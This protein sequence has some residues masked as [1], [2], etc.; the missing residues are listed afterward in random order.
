MTCAWKERHN[1]I[2]STSERRETI[3]ACFHSRIGLRPVVFLLAY[4]PCRSARLLLDRLV[5]DNHFRVPE[6]IREIL[7]APVGDIVLPNLGTDAQ[8]AVVLVH[9]LLHMQVSR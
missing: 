1:S 9:D 2:P 5:V 6:R 7:V 4:P 8:E 3:Y